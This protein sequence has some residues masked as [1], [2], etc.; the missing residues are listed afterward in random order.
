MVPKNFTVYNAQLLCSIIHQLDE[1]SSDR[2]KFEIADA[3]PSGPPS[4]SNDT[5]EKP[6]GD[7]P[8]RGLPCIIGG[9]KLSVAKTK[10]YIRLSSTCQEE[11]LF[12][13]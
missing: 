6:G 12:G 7:G 2:R 4:P 5:T 11:P 13:R 1:A 10:F 8:F 3:Q 9:F